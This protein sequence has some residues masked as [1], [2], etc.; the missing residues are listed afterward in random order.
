MS[1]LRNSKCVRFLGFNFDGYTVMET[2]ENSK[3]FS[4]YVNFKK[5]A[6]FYF[7]KLQISQAPIF[8]VLPLKLNSKNS[9]NSV[10]FQD[11]K[12]VLLI[13]KVGNFKVSKFSILMVILKL[14]T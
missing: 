5:K 9:E 13:E 12:A 6:L 11:F 7:R 14:K 3:N 4:K 10:L 1:Y 8:L 2:S